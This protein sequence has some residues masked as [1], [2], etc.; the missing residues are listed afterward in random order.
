MTN[1]KQKP[2]ELGRLKSMGI[3]E[4]WQALLMPP[5]R[6]EALA[7]VVSSST[8]LQPLPTDQTSQQGNVER[9]VVVT[10]TVAT[11][12]EYDPVR[13][14][15]QLRI[16]LNDG[17]V[18]RMM[19]FGHPKQLPGDWR[20]AGASAS[21]ACKALLGNNG[22]TLFVGPTPVPETHLD[23]ALGVYPGKAN[24]IKPETVRDRVLA[25]ISERHLE[26]ATHA[27]LSGISPYTPREL[28]DAWSLAHG[29]KRLHDEALTRAIYRLHMP[30]SPS[31]GEAAKRLLR[32]LSALAL[33]IRADRERP[34]AGVAISLHPRASDLSGRILSMEHTPTPE[35]DAAIQEALSDMASDRPMHRLLSGDVGTGKTMVFAVLAAAV[36]D[37]GGE[38]G[39]LL[40]SEDMVRQVTREIGA[41][42]PDIKVSRVTGSQPDHTRHRMRIGTTAMLS[43]TESGWQPTLMIVDE[44]QKYAS[45]QREALSQWGGHLLEA[46]ATCLP[47]TMAQLQFG[48]V[49]ASRLTHGH[50]TKDMATR[51]WN[52][53][54][55]S[56]RH[57]LFGEVRKTLA[58]NAQVLVIFAARDTKQEE[59]GEGSRVTPLEEGVERWRRVLGHDEVAVLHGRMSSA[60]R[61]ANLD[62]IRSGKARVLCATTAAEVGLNLPRLRHAIIN[63][64][65]RFGLVTLHQIRGRLARTGGWG[66][67]DL[68]A[69]T[70]NLSDRSLERL[71]AFEREN[72]GFALAELDMRQRGMGSLQ[73]SESRQSG[74]SDASLLVGEPPGFENFEAAQ[75]MLEVLPSPEATPG[76]QQDAGTQASL[77]A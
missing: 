28:L 5:N 18:I 2:P 77:Q 14:R 10:G 30:Q 73:S 75:R 8:Q 13:K 68:L 65:E 15:S 76:R 50:T 62:R 44:Q 57:Q 40:P 4:A 42:W 74:S 17:A 51:I 43:N 55:P 71:G 35:Q 70:P 49:P 46:T 59:E 22:F 26:E 66:R 56:E 54:E 67:C 69:D 47:R 6:Y 63:S 60:D 33:I 24:V 72:D 11:P 31:Q 27:I 45:H 61:A 32:D 38:V 19:A 53:Q 36:Y 41:W 9:R 34:K 25:L 3:Q 48:L 12:A 37:A 39:I 7:P 29:Y 52:R 21:F 23:R 58:E 20:R 16:R 64:P 1:N